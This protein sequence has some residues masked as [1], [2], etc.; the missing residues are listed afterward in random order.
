MMRMTYSPWD[1]GRSRTWQCRRGGRPSAG[2]CCVGDTSTSEGPSS[3]RSSQVPARDSQGKI[4]NRYSTTY[5]VGGTEQYDRYYNILHGGT[6]RYDRY[7]N[8]LLGA[9]KGMTDTTTYCWGHRKVR[10]ILQHTAWGHRKVWQILQ[11]TVGGT[12]RYDR[13]YNIL[14]GAQKGMTYCVGG[15][16]QYDRYYNILLGAQKG[17]TD[18]TTYCEGH[19]KLRQILHID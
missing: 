8:I 11:H 15:K 7:Y 1:R 3:A 4:H 13:Y 9:Q 12:E 14:L 16:E 19:S 6:E 5:C 2:S 18:T 10:Q 17:M